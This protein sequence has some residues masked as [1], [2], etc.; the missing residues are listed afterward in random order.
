MNAWIKPTKTSNPRKGS[1][2][3]SGA[4]DANTSNITSPA[5][6]LPKSRKE[7]EMILANSLIVSRMPTKNSIAPNTKI[8]IEE[9]RPIKMRSHGIG[10]VASKDERNPSMTPAIG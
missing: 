4:S 9:A 10:L 2:S 5:N 8:K 1:V 7:N 6:I 3:T